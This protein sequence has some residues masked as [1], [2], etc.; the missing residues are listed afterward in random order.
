MPITRFNAEKDNTITNAYSS[1]LRSRATGSNMGS[2]DS[3]EIFSIYGQATTSSLEKSRILIQFPTKNI[4]NSRTLNKI[5]KSGSVRFYLKLF[6]AVHP[7][8]TPERYHIC[9]SPLLQEWTEGIG[10]D[11][12]TYKDKDVSNWTQSQK[13]INWNK[14]GSSYADQSILS[15]NAIPT[16]RTQYFEKGTEN[17]ELEITDYVEEW[18]KDYAGLST[19]A[20]GSIELLEVP[21]L[22]TT[23]T[24]RTTSG[25]SKTLLVTSSAGVVGSTTKIERSADLPT[26]QSRI[27]SAIDALTDFSSNKVSNTI[28]ITQSSKGYFGNTIIS[29]SL[30]ETGSNVTNF[31]NGSGIINNGLVVKL[32][33]SAEDGTNT[34]SYYT[35]K[36]FS[37]GTEFFFYKPVIESQWDN[38][39]SDDRGSIFKSSSLVSSADNINNLYLYNRIRGSLVDIPNTGSHLV[40]QLYTSSAGGAPINLVAAGGVTLAASSFITASKED[41]GVY[42]AQFVY[43]GNKNELIDVWSSCVGDT[44]TTLATGSLFSIESVTAGSNY[45]VPSYVLNINNLKNSYDKTELATFRVHT[46]TSDWSPNIYS[47]ATNSAKSS[48]IKNA[49]YKIKRVTDAH[50]VIPYSTGSS[51]K[52]SKL[53]YDVSGSFFNLDMSILEPNYLYEISFLFQ[54]GENYKEQ[55]ERFRFRVQ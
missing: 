39:I 54:E 7:S 40:V 19:A 47:V 9:V 27:V 3:L 30:S 29:S 18:I 4:S 53:S 5:P 31:S 33:G 32:S 43:S 52:Y 22:E 34:R 26:M 23:I 12:E 25:A 15:S 8:T 41:K 45:Q 2:S 14:S 50:T 36:F 11:M 24:L 51:E 37:R 44:L 17:L 20:Q 6:N 13:N 35:K 21:D 42:R 46:R 28:H 1:G 10:L 55:K 38:S 49:F 48:V 16:E